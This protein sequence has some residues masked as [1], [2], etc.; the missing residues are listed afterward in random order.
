MAMRV[1][2]TGQHSQSIFSI[3]YPGI[4]WNLYILSRAHGTDHSVTKYYCTGVIAAEFG[5]NR[6]NAGINDR[7]FFGCGSCPISLIS[8]VSYVFTNLEKR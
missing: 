7:R 2:E 5:I 1:Y 3:D 6:V 8:T 4:I